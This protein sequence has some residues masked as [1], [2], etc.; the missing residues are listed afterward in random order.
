MCMLRNSFNYAVATSV[1]LVRTSH[2]SKYGNQRERERVYLHVVAK[3]KRIFQW[4][5]LKKDNCME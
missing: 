1:K 2:K 5:E 3:D 4:I